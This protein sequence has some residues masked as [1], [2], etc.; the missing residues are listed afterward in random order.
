M[1]MQHRFAMKQAKSTNALHCTDDHD[2]RQHAPVANLLLVQLLN[3]ALERRNW[4]PQS[5][6]VRI[7]ANALLELAI[8]LKLFSRAPRACPVPSWKPPIIR[9]DAAE[10]VLRLLFEQIGICAV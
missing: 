6:I 8:S 4:R 9:N 1:P 10:L 2:V 7:N 5:S 3:L